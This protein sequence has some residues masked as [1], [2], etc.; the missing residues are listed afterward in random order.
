MCRSLALGKALSVACGDNSPT[1]RAKG[2]TTGMKSFGTESPFPTGD[3]L[4]KWNGTQA[5]PY[6]KLETM[7]GTAKAVPF[8]AFFAFSV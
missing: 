2:A 1:G 5:V 8:E 6:K 3:D 7:Q 4:R